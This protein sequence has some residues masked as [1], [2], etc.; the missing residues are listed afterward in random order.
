MHHAFQQVFHDNVNNRVFSRDA[1]AVPFVIYLTWK[2]NK[3][4]K[5]VF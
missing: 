5:F 2:Q 1:L 3:K 4:N